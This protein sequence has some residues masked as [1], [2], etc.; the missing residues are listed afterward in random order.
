MT[1]EHRSAWRV[2]AVWLVAGIPVAAIVAG[3]GLVI[4]AMRQP[5]DA[6]GDRVQRTAQIQVADLGADEQAR[7]TGL[8]ALLRVE[9]GVVEAL[10]IAGAFDRG[11]PLVLSLRH[12]ARAAE[13]RRVELA[14]TALGWRAQ[15]A[16]DASHDW[17]VE[18]APADGRWRLLGR[19]PK[20]QHA[21]ALQPALQSGRTD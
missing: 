21:V 8:R 1:P 2:P 4:V 11:R 18:L 12:P 15:A 3:V 17:L 6:I 13:D 14:P 7:R 10:P 16:V 19:L 9:Y 5:N 20:G